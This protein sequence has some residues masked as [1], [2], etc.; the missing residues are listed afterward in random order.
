MRLTGRWTRGGESPSRLVWEG[1]PSQANELLPI[2]GM[3]VKRGTATFPPDIELVDQVLSV[4]PDTEVAQDVTDW[5]YAERNREQLLSAV[6]V[7][8]DWDL[9]GCED[10]RPYQRV[11]VRYLLEARR[12]ILADDRGLG[13]TAVAIRATEHLHRVLVVAP[14]Y[15]KG[16]WAEEIRK[17]SSQPALVV[18]GDRVKRERQIREF[19]EGYCIVNYEMVRR[20]DRRLGAGGHQLLFDMRWDAIICDEAHRLKDRNS[21]QTKGVTLLSEKVP[22]I[23][24]LTG[25]PMVNRDPSELWSLLRIIDP[26][27][28]TSYWAFVARFCESYT[29]YWG[30]HISGGKN[31]PELQRVL[32]SNMLR[33]MKSTVAPELPPK[34]YKTIHVELTAEHRRLYTRVEDEMLLE[35]EDA[36]TVSIANSLAAIARLQQVALFPGSLGMSPHEPKTETLISLIEDVLV[37]EGQVVV[38]GWHKA[39]L[40]HLSRI[41][42]GKKWR[43]ALITGDTPFSTRDEIVRDFRSGK[44][45]VLLGN[46]AAVGEGLNLD[47]ASTAIFVESTW[48][49]AKNEQAEDRLHRLTTTQSPTIIHLVSKDTIDEDIRAVANR[50][51]EFV[52]RVLGPDQ[53]IR[54]VRDRRKES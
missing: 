16:N 46:L 11:G 10:L 13:K 38:F 41:L 22:I 24:M 15:L 39:Y 21:L 40:E 48:T 53:I 2:P 42:P 20:S 3:S 26:N 8:P 5:M 9:P 49:A 47:T 33:R 35:L 4:W 52:A 45:D 54:T 30:T 1:Q 44:Y 29:D 50:K 36:S 25:T 19:T 12:A 17:W 37:D 28:W 7:C 27:R 6:A 18:E 32:K 43:V 31:I 14:S 34:L 23:Y 51:G